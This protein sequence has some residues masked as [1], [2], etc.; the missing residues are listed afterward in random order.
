MNGPLLSFLLYTVMEKLLVKGTWYT[1]TT[2]STCD[3]VDAEGRP[4]GTAEAGKQLTF[5]ASTERITFSDDAAEVQAENFSVALVPGGSGGLGEKELAALGLLDAG[6]VKKERSKVIAGSWAYPGMSLPSTCVVSS[7][8]CELYYVFP[9]KIKANAISI[10]CVAE[11]VPRVAVNGVNCLFKSIGWRGGML[12]EVHYDMPP[13]EADEF[14]IVVMGADELGGGNTSPNA[15]LLSGAID[16]IYPYVM[17]VQNE[18]ELIYGVLTECYMVRVVRSNGSPSY[19]Q[20]DAMLQAMAQ[21]LMS[22]GGGVVFD[23]GSFS[24]GPSAVGCVGFTV[25]ISKNKEI[26]LDILAEMEA[27]YPNAYSGLN[28]N[29]VRLR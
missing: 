6:E 26:L 28:L 9:K 25:S 1:V 10:V 18:A 27:Y 5:K 17:L 3:V 13:V 21:A 22:E 20:D 16:D 4:L 2:G 24:A 14:S 11:D 19:Y 15:E 7:A 29:V 23:Y 8:Y 12:A